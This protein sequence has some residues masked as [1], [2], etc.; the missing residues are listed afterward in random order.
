MSTKLSTL[1]KR[2]RALLQHA[3]ARCYYCSAPLT[4]PLH[5]REASID[6]K[7]PVSRGGTNSVE[8]TVLACFPCNKDKGDMTEEEFAVFRAQRRLGL[9]KKKALMLAV[10]ECL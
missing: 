3:D 1:A 5:G 10:L 2:R 6:H 8:N 7:L 4:D 9:S